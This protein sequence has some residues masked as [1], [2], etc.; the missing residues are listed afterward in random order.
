MFTLRRFTEILPWGWQKAP[1]LER[2]A[3][4]HSAR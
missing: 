1:G 3:T 4:G 2:P